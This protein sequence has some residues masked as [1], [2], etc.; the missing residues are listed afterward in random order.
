M[1]DVVHLITL[2]EDYEIQNPISH[3]CRDARYCFLAQIHVE[4][5]VSAYQ[6]APAA[7]AR[8]TS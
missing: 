2:D 1:N 8:C 6:H 4:E 5:C 3:P 7:T